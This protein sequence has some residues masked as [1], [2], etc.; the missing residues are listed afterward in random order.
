ML[1]KRYIIFRNVLIREIKASIIFSRVDKCTRKGGELLYFCGACKLRGC[2]D[3]KS[4]DYKN[5]YFSMYRFCTNVNQK[6][7]CS[8]IVSDVV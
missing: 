7:E 8:Y 1:N 2:I 3:Y 6:H 5:N 4:I